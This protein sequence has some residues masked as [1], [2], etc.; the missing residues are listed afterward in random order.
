MNRAMGAA[1]SPVQIDKRAVKPVASRR[2]RVLLPAPMKPI[3]TSSEAGDF[4]GIEGD[5]SS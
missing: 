5:C 1:L 2:P 3:R 4:F